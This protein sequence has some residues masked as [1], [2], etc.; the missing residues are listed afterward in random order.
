[1]TQHVAAPPPAPPAPGH[2]LW[3][4]YAA[5][6]LAAL[7]FF[8]LYATERFT[9]LARALAWLGLGLATLPAM[10]LLTRPRAP[11]NS[12]IAVGL[13]T[14]LFYHL[15]V[16]HERY[17]GLRWG[18]AR[19]TDASVE[20]A[21][22]LAALAVP[23]LWLGWLLSG[24]L[25]LRRMVPHLRIDVSLPLLRR[26]GVGIALTSLL[27]NVGWAYGLLPNSGAALSVLGVLTP[28]ELGMAMILMPSLMGQ[29]GRND[30]RI[31]WGLVALYGGIS[32]GVGQILL[33]IRPL[34]IYILGWLLVARRLRLRPLLICL[35]I[36]VVLQPVKAEFRS[37]TWDRP[38]ELSLGERAQL[39]V[40][41]VGEH[42]L[43]DTQPV[44]T[45]RALETAAARTAAALAL[46]NY[47]ELTPSAV[48]YQLGATYRYFQYALIPRVFYPDKPISQYADVWAAVM[49][50]YTS[51]AGTA[52][53]MV[54]LSQMGESYVNF[55]FFGALLALML[56]GALYRTLDE[57]LSHPQAGSGAL[58]IYLYCTM[59]LM[60]AT[61]GS[62]AQAWGAMPQT[63]IFYGVV[64]F[65]LSLVGRR[66]GQSAA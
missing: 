38:T 15:A 36:V 1:M 63:L 19:I 37:R 11:R 8:L 26:V 31:F 46:A 20:R 28:A 27:A 51:W 18:H 17:L 12:V 40:E 5:S 43:G 6:L 23:A 64:M 4:L 52:H 10:V 35:T 34:I 22:L 9:P 56:I 66:R 60:I 44:D 24:T 33:F 50:G 58:A 59:N 49:Y 53:V 47:V 39:Y 25:A 55:G 42:W 61:E 7:P 48:P 65:A 16:F 62:T 14:V 32:L 54:G 30:R 13:V 45:G 57:L 41:L 21:M 29:P 2:R 3:L